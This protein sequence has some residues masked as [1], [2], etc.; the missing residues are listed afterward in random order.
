ME[1]TND[2]KEL[3]RDACYRAA[4][5]E[6]CGVIA[7]GLVYELTNFSPHPGTFHIRG[8]E[9]APIVTTH[10][11]YDAVWH[12]H[13]SGDVLPS[14]TDRANHPWPAALVIATRK[15]V[16]VYAHEHAGA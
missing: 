3:M 16:A 2:Q 9:L 1:L 6:A 15:T 13:P 8:S 12:T 4:P 14:A 5:R 11:G 10:G 7:G